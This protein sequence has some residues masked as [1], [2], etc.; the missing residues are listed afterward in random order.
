M[1]IL[2]QVGSQLGG[3]VQGVIGMGSVIGKTILLGGLV[4][5]ITW[6][7]LEQKKYKRTVFVERVYGNNQRKLFVD[8]AKRFK[9]KDGVLRWKL[10]KLNRTTTVPPDDAIGLMA[11]GREYAHCTLDSNDQVTWVQAELDYSKHKEE[12]LKKGTYR[13]ITTESRAN[14]AHQQAVNKK[15]RTNW[16]KENM[17][18]VVGGIAIFLIVAVVFVFLPKTIDAYN[19]IIQ[20]QGEITAKQSALIDRIDELLN[21]RQVISAESTDATPAPGSAGNGDVPVVEAPN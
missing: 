14:Y 18:L 12:G 15:F 21:E 8:V 20:T 4:L 5:V 9:D 19:G 10:K 7:V 2:G 6:W 17:P 1:S 11:S 16:A 3:L 13:P